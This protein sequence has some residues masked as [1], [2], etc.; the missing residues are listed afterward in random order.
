MKLLVPK[1]ESGGS[2]SGADKSE[3]VGVYVVRACLRAFPITPFRIL[4][5]TL[6]AGT[7]A[8]A[9]AATGAGGPSGG[10]MARLRRWN[11]INKSEDCEPEDGADIEGGE[12][13]K[14]PGKTGD[15]K[16]LL[17]KALKVGAYLFVL[18]AFGDGFVD[19]KQGGACAG[20]STAG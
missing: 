9:A 18:L 3:F 12:A 13:G 7:S 4:I 17:F 6:T 19:G 15:T 2:G 20:T 14:G 5:H 11:I 16:A 10:L 8:A 1:S